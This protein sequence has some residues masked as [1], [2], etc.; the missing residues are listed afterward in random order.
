MIVAGLHAKDFTKRQQDGRRPHVLNP[1]GFGLLVAAMALIASGATETLTQAKALSTTIDIP[2]QIFVVLFCLGLVVQHFFAVTL[3]TFAATVVM[4]LINLGYTWTTGVYLFA[5]TNLPAAAFLGLHLLMTDPSTSPRT[6][7]GRT[8]FGAGYGLGYVVAFEVLS[9]LGAPELFAKLFP[10][11]I[12]NTCVQALDRLART[13][14]T[15]RLEAKWQSALRP[16]AMNHVHMALWA[17]VFFVM[18]G[19]GYVQAPHPGDSI[20]FWK[21]AFAD[22]KP[23]AGRKLVMVAGTRAVAGRSVGERAHALN[24][25]GVISIEGKVADDPEPKAMKSAADWWAKA[26]ALGSVEACANILILDLF[27]GARSSDRAPDMAFQRLLDEVRKEK[28]GLTAFLIGCAFEK[29]GDGRRAVQFYRMCGREDRLAVKGIVRITLA[30]GAGPVDLSDY[31]GLLERAAEQG[32]GESCWY[33]AYMRARG[34]GV[35]ANDGKAAAMRARA[36]ELGFPPA[37]EA[38][39]GDLP[40]YSPPGWRVRERPA[41]ATAFPVAGS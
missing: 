16:S 36:E 39:G 41:W 2:P 24:E 9:R 5:G 14:W 31:A 26:A 13:G 22:G 18:L 30:G 4:V 7:L 21:R 3:M 28:G 25:L 8:L 27:D 12:L 38:K 40:D 32:D 17:A 29:G 11:P 35:I 20:P 33:L 23:D 6:N 34:L 15:G 10:V 19:T 37:V 1:S